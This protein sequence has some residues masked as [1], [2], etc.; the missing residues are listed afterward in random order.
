MA[1]KS[2]GHPLLEGIDYSRIFEEGSTLEQV[3]AIYANV[4]EFDESGQVVNGR[5]AERRAAQFIL[6]HI[7]GR[8]E[9]PPFEP[10]EVALHTPPPKIDPKSTP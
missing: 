9:E 1:N 10:W 2:V 7:T 4:L 5:Y 6:R 8:P 3:Y